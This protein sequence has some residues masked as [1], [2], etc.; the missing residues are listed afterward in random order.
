MYYFYEQFTIVFYYIKSINWGLIESIILFFK[1]DIQINKYNDIENGA[2]DFI[3]NGDTELLSL[4][5]VKE[6]WWY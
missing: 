1:R 4:S 5:I 3:T 6:L 2:S